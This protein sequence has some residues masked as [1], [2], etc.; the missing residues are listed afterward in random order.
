MN[1]SDTEYGF[2]LPRILARDRLFA[3]LRVTT[4]VRVTAVLG[5]CFLCGCASPEVGRAP[6]SSGADVK[7]WGK[8]IEM[9]AGAQ[10]YHETPC[11]TERVECHGPLPVF[12][13]TPPPD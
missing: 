5:V 11:V 7:N 12:G 2:G 6:G 13:A 4:V 8:P 1:G 10:P 3:A 9:H